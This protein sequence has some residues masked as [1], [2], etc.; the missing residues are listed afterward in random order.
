MNG[1]ILHRYL[2][3]WMNELSKRARSVDAAHWAPEHLHQ[4]GLQSN[5]KDSKC[6]MLRN[7]GTDTV[8]LKFYNSFF[9]TEPQRYLAEWGPYNAGPW[10][11][12]PHS[13]CLASSLSSGLVAAASRPGGGPWP[14]EHDQYWMVWL[15][16]CAAG[17]TLPNFP[18]EHSEWP[19]GMLQ[20]QACPACHKTL[21][22]SMCLAV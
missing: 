21:L 18:Y 15:C 14:G 22:S 2:F 13:D 1:W 19:A 20:R 5:I 6:F 3:W 7:A 17:P 11:W 9:N 16:S 10:T 4:H 12:R 8:W